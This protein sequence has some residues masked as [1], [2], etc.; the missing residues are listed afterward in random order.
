MEGEDSRSRATRAAACHRFVQ[1][2]RVAI[3]SSNG[4]VYRQGT[5]SEGRARGG[6]WHR[7]LQLEFTPAGMG[8]HVSIEPRLLNS[9]TGDAE[10]KISR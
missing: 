10:G 8:P 5:Q 1:D 9:A 4:G 7:S 2:E 6:Y 3:R